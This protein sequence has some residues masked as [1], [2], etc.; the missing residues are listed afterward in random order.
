MKKYLYDEDIGDFLRAIESSPICGKDWCD[1]C[2]DC[3]A[4]NGSDECFGND[5][6][7]HF[8][9]EYIKDEKNETAE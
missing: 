8:W 1:S 6:R 7:K 2:G 4:C 5:S 3:L 9:V